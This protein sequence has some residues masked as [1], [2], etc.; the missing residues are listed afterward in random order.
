MVSVR[1]PAALDEVYC[2][3]GIASFINMHKLLLVIMNLGTA[4]R[5]MLETSNAAVNPQ[6]PAATSSSH[7]ASD[8]VLELKL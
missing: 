5:N 2:F 6:Q 8:K 7:L 1:L 3:L 4:S